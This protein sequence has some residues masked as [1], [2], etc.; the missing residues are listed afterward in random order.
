MR[1]KA[2]MAMAVVFCAVGVGQAQERMSVVDALKDLYRNF[3]PDKSTAQWDCTKEQEKKGPHQG[4]PCTA[5]NATVRVSGV[6]LAEVGED[7]TDTTFLVASAVPANAPGGYECHACQPAIGVAVFVAQEGNWAWQNA[8]P[9]TGFYG[10]W[11]EAPQVD[12]VWVGPHKRGLLLTNTDMAQGYAWSRKVLLMRT[13][14]TIEEVW[15]MEDEG[16]NAG[17]ID[18]A[19]KTDKRAGYRWSAAMRFFAGEPDDRG[20]GGYESYYDI[21]VISRGNAS[22]NAAHPK[23][24]NWTEVYRFKDGRYRLVRREEFVE[25]KKAA[26]TGKKPAGKAGR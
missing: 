10:G 15:S 6:M 2:L 22:E 13:E 7:G 1:V 14:R 19:D 17:A 3:D 4:W 11:G 20:A 9:A 21:E 12:L 18:P 16:D 25:G 24:E 23:A 5:E 8:N 26:G